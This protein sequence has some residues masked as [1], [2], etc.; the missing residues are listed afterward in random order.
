MSQPIDMQAFKKANVKP[1]APLDQ[2]TL[3]LSIQVALSAALPPPIRNGRTANGADVELR[4]DRFKII[5]TNY[6][7]FLK[8]MFEELN[9]NLP[10]DATVRTADIFAGLDDI[11]SDAVWEME[12]AGDRDRM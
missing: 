10:M 8:K 12:K 2:H 3:E 4:I 6:V 7:E 5:H 11:A 1:V 9:E